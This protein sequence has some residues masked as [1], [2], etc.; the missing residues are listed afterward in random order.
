MNFVEFDY[1]DK[2]FSKKRGM[3]QDFM[4]I[5]SNKIIEGQR[6]QMSMI[7]GIKEF[8]DVANDITAITGATRADFAF[9][10]SIL[11]YDN[12]NSSLYQG[13]QIG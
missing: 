8:L 13:Q 11:N 12:S 3:A 2:T 10:T 6:D 4:Q 1:S 5:R 7:Q 9:N